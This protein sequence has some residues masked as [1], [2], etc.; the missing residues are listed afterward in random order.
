MEAIMTSDEKCKEIVQAI[1]DAFLN[2]GNHSGLSLV[3]KAAIEKKLVELVVIIKAE[4]I[5]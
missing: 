3:G 4:I 5:Q 1:D 2:L